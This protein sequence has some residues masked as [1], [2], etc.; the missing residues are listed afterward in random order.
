MG[1]SNREYV[2]RALEVLATHLDQYISHALEAVAPGI[3]WPKLLEHK[4]AS[5]GRSP[6]TYS[7]KDLS[8]Q[9]RVMTEPLG[10]LGYPFNLGHE[11][12]SYTSELRQTRNLWA[13]NEPFVDADAYRALDTSGRLAK[14]LGLSEA[15]KQLD[16]LFNEFKERGLA[17]VPAPEPTE[18]TATDG[19][20]QPPAEPGNTKRR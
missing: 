8:V 2:G 17:V 4:D 15:A 11:A 6:A 3:S 13:H 14:Q 20:N 5:A 9:L 19:E 7:A 10:S 16:T 1:L 18:P 12:R